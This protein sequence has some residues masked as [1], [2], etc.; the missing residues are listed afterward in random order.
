VL[1]V[2]VV[3][4][5]GVEDFILCPYP[6]AGCAASPGEGWPGGVHL[7]AGPLFLAPIQLLVRVSLWRWFHAFD[8]VL[9]TF[10]Y[11]DVEV[12]LLEQL[13]GGGR[14]FLK[15]GSDEG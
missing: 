8:E 11:G 7:L 15:Y 1:H 9:G 4:A 13:F 10:I 6:S 14:C 3:W 2:L 12:C 5:L